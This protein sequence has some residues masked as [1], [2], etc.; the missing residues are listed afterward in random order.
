MKYLNLRLPNFSLLAFILFA[1]TV[2]AQGTASIKGVVHTSDN[3]P[4]EGV[5]VTV[6]GLNRTTI[7]DNNG[8]FTIKNVPNGNF[9]L[10]VT[11]VGYNDV[12]QNVTVTAGETATVNI[13]LSLSNN[14]LN[15]VVV[16]SNKSA[17][18]TNRVSSSL[19]LQSPIIEIPQNIQVVTGKLIQDQQIFDMLEGVTRNVS[20]ATRVE[21]W[22]NYANITMRGSQV[23]AFRNGMN[24]STSWGPLTEDMSMVERIE[25]V[26]GPAGFMLANG[27]PSGFYN[28]V[29]KK[30]SGRTKGEASISLGSFDMYRAALDFDGKLQ[31]TE[32]Y[33][34]VLMLWDKIKEVTVSLTYNNRY[35]YC[36][37]I[38][39]FNR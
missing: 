4:A 30:P 19:R 36:T 13:N 20:G 26:K 23:S 9:T 35:Y 11:L 34:I 25:F 22:D 18:K 10:I 38:K 3:K 39:I 1:A 21:H 24:V 32:N 6:K 17:F 33:C 28:V 8:A 31:K 12:E 37:R 29:T 16:L 7:A 5:S 27:N 2:F 15:Q 14:E